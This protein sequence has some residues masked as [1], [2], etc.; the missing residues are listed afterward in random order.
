MVFCV[1]LYVFDV[2]P[3]FLCVSFP[4]SL[5]RL[6]L[7]RMVG[8]FTT[9]SWSLPASSLA[10]DREAAICSG[11]SAKSTRTTACA[12][13][14]RPTLDSQ[15]ALMTTKPLLARRSGAEDVSPPSA[16]CT[17][18]RQASPEPPSRCPA[19]AEAEAQRTSCWSK[20]FGQATRET[21]ECWN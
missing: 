17:T 13:R 19:S 14:I 15:R 20:Q 11:E 3:V 2:M 16:T 1:C 4:N 10:C 8:T 6:L 7:K 12:T 5:N 18:T 21:V 9:L